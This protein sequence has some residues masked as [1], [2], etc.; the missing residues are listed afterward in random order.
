MSRVKRGIIKAK[1]R[2]NIL[3]KVK[4]YSYGRKNKKKQAY[5]AIA[6]AGVHAFNHRRDKKG[7]FRRLW[8]VRLNAAI[9]PFGL[10]YSRLI[11][12]LNKKDI[13]LNRKVLSEI[14]HEH[15]ETFE[16]IAKEVT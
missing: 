4:G 12:A 1:S 2:R 15:P 7:D 11:D 10:S 8:T 14:A 3:E 6:H 9:R 16:R 13:G 5:E